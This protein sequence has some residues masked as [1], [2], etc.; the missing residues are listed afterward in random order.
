MA[1]QRKA[2]SF[3]EEPITHKLTERGE[4]Q[5][6]LQESNCSTITSSNGREGISESR[7]FGNGCPD[8]DNVLRYAVSEMQGWRSHME[9]KHALNPKLSTNKQQKELLKNHH[10]FAVFDGHGGDYASHFCGENLVE[11]LIGQKD[12]HAYLKLSN[13]SSGYG[14]GN[15]DNRSNAKGLALLKSALTSTFLELDDKLMDAQRRKRKSQLSNL[16]DLVFSMGGAAEHDVFEKGTA[17]HNRVMN[18]D[19]QMPSSMPA[20][21]PLE[22][23]GS[24]GVVVLMT[25]SHILC[26]NAGDS[27]AILSKRNKG[28]PVLP[29]SFDHKP[30]ND[31]EVGRI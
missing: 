28:E 6:T 23:S 27:R 16:E 24:T 15:A 22:R 25:P 19:K 3:L 14:R 9:D 30:N 21:V 7:S 11:T 31:V 20:Y 17:D 8:T 13:S 26:A 2:S 18:F 29:L 1:L 5:V 10:L 4:A 12:W